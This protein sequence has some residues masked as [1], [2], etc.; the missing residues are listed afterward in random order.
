M[1]TLTFTRRLRDRYGTDTGQIRDDESHMRV[2]E[3][4]KDECTNDRNRTNVEL[5]SKQY[6]GLFGVLSG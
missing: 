5:I 3:L 2:I 4:T 6:R 1:A